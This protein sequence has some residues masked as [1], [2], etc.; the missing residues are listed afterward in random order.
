MILKSHEQ[1][2][3]KHKQSGR[4]AEASIINTDGK[5]FSLLLLSALELFPGD[6]I[7]LEFFWWDNTSYIVQANVIETD[8]NMVHVLQ[9]RENLCRM[10]RR[11]FQRILSNA[12]VEFVLLPEKDPQTL[13]EGYIQDISRNGLRLSVKKPLEIGSKLYLMF[14]DAPCNETNFTVAVNGKVVRKE[15]KKCYG[16]KFDSPLPFAVE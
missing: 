1:I 7:E 13:Q 14:E 9:D 3:V 2:K 11:K 4:N 16:I 10:Q 5:E 6:E 12:K 8:A 15:G